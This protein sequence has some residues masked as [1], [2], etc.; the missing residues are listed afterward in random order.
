MTASVVGC[1]AE[2]PTFGVWSTVNLGVIDLYATDITSNDRDIFEPVLERV[3][4]DP[5]EP[6]TEAPEAVT[7][8]V[9][10]SA[11][12][13][14]QV[15]WESMPGATTTEQPTSGQGGDGEGLMASAM[16]E[17]AEEI[18][19]EPAVGADLTAVAPPPL[20]VVADA[21]AAEEAELP[22]LCPVVPIGEV[23]P[24]TSHPSTPP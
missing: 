1:I 15:G 12:A 21:G 8:A 3:L 18:L 24:T 13:A 19:G 11:E 14:A 4:A 10:S 7:S 2:V 20:T 6:E 17:A 16:S 23:A 22:L 9:A 5:A